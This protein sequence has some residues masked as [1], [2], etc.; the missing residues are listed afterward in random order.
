MLKD[1]V[2]ELSNLGL[3]AFAITAGDEEVFAEDDSSVIDHPGVDRQLTCDQAFFFLGAQVWPDHRLSYGH[4]IS[5]RLFPGLTGNF[6]FLK[7]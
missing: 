2:N 4:R 5:W 1:K 3:K 6:L 7:S